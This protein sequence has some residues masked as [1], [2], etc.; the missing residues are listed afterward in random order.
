MG[1]GGGSEGSG[2][3]SPGHW[4]ARKFSLIELRIPTMKDI[5]GGR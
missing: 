5:F 3:Y 2:G 4:Y 1:F